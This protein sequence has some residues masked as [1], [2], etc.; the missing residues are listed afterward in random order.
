MLIRIIKNLTVVLCFLLLTA[1]SSPE[2]IAM[3][4][5]AKGIELYHKGEYAKAELELKS[6]IQQDPTVADAYYYLA[7]VNEKNRNFKSM[8]DNLIE[9]IKLK[10]ENLDAKLRL[11]KVLLLLNEAETALVQIKEILQ[12]EADNLDAKTLE[13]SILIRQNKMSEALPILDEV[14][15]QDP[16]HNDALSLKAAL[17]MEGQNFNEALSLI[18]PAIDS[19][20]DN[21]S[22]RLLK[23]K[24]DAQNKDIDAVITDYQDLIRI[25][26]EK[27]ELKYALAKIYSAAKKNQEAEHILTELVDQ[28]PNDIQ[29]KLIL[30]GFIYQT[31]RNRTDEVLQS[32]IKSSQEN[33]KHLLELAKWT[34]MVNNVSSAKQQLK[35]IAENKKFKA[36]VRTEADLLLANIYFEQ[37]DY[38]ATSEAVQAILNK[39]PNQIGAKILKAKVWVQEGQLEEASALLNTV[40]WDMPN[41]DEAIVLMGDIFLKQGELDKAQKNFKE[42]LDINPANLQALFPVVEKAVKENHLDYAAQLLT[43][44]LA[45]RRNQVSLLNKLVQIKMV[46]KDWD[47]AEKLITAMESQPKSIFLAKFLR[48][49][50]YQEQG[51]CNKA[52]PLFKETLAR[53]PTQA[54]S[55]TEVARCHEMLKQRPK[56]LSYLNDLIKDGPANISAIVLKSKLMTL[57]RQFDHA[58][59]LL[60]KAIDDYPN[61]VSLYSELARVYSQKNQIKDALR[62]YQLG[63]ENNPGSLELSMLLASTYVDQKKYDEAV[64]IYHQVI[65]KNLKLDIARNNLAAILL[66]HYG[67]ADDIEKAVQLVQRFKYSDEPYFIDTYAWAEFKAGRLNQ[68]LSILQKVIVAAP[69]VPVFRYHLASVYHALGNKSAALSEL[70]QVM[71]LAKSTQFDQ[72]DDAKQL[73]RRNYSAPHYK[74]HPISH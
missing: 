31:D 15:K 52:I 37:G 74:N 54:D 48:G 28:R 19:D 18:Q 33:P 72:L 24:I 38:K 25:F 44:A 17:L 36:D 73:M 30:L 14:L 69:D 39:N 57:D 32:F 55:L 63:L 27:D 70:R 26:P 4:S 9:A 35:E 66:D 29:Q 42:A 5:Q 12:Q 50:L 40:L 56:M 11:G 53:Y 6:A 49:K 43:K 7:L 61:S 23:I 62:T 1:C 47:S 71:E 13:A 20:R 10:P 3:D 59:T 22:L 8:K 67:Q 34:L 2:E 46:Q 65:E 41:S 51:D 21:L 64:A 58:V 68:A 60:K 16:M 45:R